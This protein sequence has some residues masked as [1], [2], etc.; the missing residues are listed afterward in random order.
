M[1][2]AGWTTGGG[3]NGTA[4]PRPAV[5]GTEP[6]FELENNDRTES[7]NLRPLPALRS[8]IPEDQRQVAQDVYEVRNVL[9]LL[10][11]DSAFGKKGNYDEFLTRLLQAGHVGCVAP[12]VHTVLAAS[13]IEQI[14]ADI[15]RRVGRPLV[16]WYLAALAGWAL[17]GLAV[18]I[19]GT[20][21]IGRIIAASANRPLWQAVIGVDWVFLGAMIG[22]WFSVAASRWQIAFDTIPDYLDRKVEPAVRIL[23][24][25]VG[26]AVFALFLHLNL[27]TI[28]IGD[29]D[30]AHFDNFISTALLVG[31]VA[32]IGERVLSVQLLGRAKS[33]LTPGS[34]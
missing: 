14:R 32:G 29:V 2:E 18:G 8:P 24:V 6:A 11:E 33:P 34:A 4:P 22:T 20:Y 15:V 5:A 21:L 7:F 1:P 10:K 17:V 25:V 28:K 3:T 16:Y 13:A 31:F 26:A 19:G 9:R 23:F 27:L 12:Y 30:F